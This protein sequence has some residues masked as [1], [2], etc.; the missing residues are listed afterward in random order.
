MRQSKPVSR[1]Y[2]SNAHDF[3][4]RIQKCNSNEEC[5]DTISALIAYCDHSDQEDFVKEQVELEIPADMSLDALFAG[6]GTR[7]RTYTYKQ[8]MQ[9]PEEKKQLVYRAMD[10]EIRQMI[11]KDVW[12]EADLP[13]SKAP[14]E[15]KWVILEKHDATSK[16]LK[17]KARIV[18]HGFKQQPGDDYDETH[19]PTP[20]MATVRLALSLIPALSL[21]PRQ[22]DVV[23]AYLEAPINK[24]LYVSHPPTYLI[25]PGKVLKLNRAL[26]G[27]RQAG[28]EFAEHRNAQLAKL[29][30]CQS[31][32]DP[33]FFY[34]VVQDPNAPDPNNA[35]PLFDFIIWWVDDGLSGF[36]EDATGNRVQRCVDEIGKVM[37]IDD[38]GTP[39]SYVGIS[40]GFS[41]NNK[42]VY[43]YQLG[44]IDEIISVTRMEDSKPRNTPLQ[45]NYPIPKYDGPPVPGFHNV[46]YSSILGGIN[47]LACCTRPDIANAVRV[48]AAHSSN[49]SA[50][51]WKQLNHLIRYLKHTHNY[52][53]CFGLPHP[54]I[55]NTPNDNKNIS[56]ENRISVFCDADWASE[57]D[58]VSVSGYI[59]Y[60][61]G[62]PINWGSKK[63][64]GTIALSSME[65]ETVAG[66]N[67][68]R[69]A[70][71]LRKFWNDLD[72]TTLWPINVGIDNQAAIY[73]GNADADH[74][75]AK[76]IDL[77]YC[78][79]KSSVR[80]GSAKL[81]YCPSVHMPADLLTKTLPCDK[82]LFLMRM[83][84]MR[85]IKE[86]C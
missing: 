27:L 13:E 32:V 66:C 11:D 60:F 29:G 48:L 81:W 64:T 78:Y 5:E 15:T 42:L 63:Q 67:G 38:K 46:S 77:R 6:F 61:L 72:P 1:A 79:I 68:I 39:S 17:F 9:L 44:L 24:E 71:W 75:R 34:R 73:F 51:A 12:A 23:S 35:K 80:N 55:M 28:L 40:L 50:H 14:I 45:N 56:K 37:L 43:A 85:K 4:D 86:V 59:S 16:F 30:Y 26:Y 3:I 10:K 70:A 49:P 2:I 62:S 83:F 69:D 74:T 8:A 21:V 53:I 25:T 58:Q 76:H 47:Y 36:S 7:V 18:A 65:A 52:V 22:L 54:L 31:R 84:A 41:Q 19:A 57:Q 33:T 82:H 20:R